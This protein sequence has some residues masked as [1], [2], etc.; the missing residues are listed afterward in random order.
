MTE[1]TIVAEVRKARK[2]LASHA[3]FDLQV[4]IERARE[5]QKLGGR[6]VVSFAP[7]RWSQPS[8]ARTNPLQ[9]D[10]VTGVTA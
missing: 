1:E 9:S 2:E 5:R 3:N 6:K 7:V 8:T 10:S 4:M